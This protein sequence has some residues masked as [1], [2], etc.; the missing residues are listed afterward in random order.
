MTSVLPA[1][2]TKERIELTEKN[3]AKC[4][5]GNVLW[6]ARIKGLHLRVFPENK[7]YY[8]YFRTKAGV[9]RKPSLGRHGSITL[10]QARTA[11]GELLEQVAAGRDPIAEREAE[12]NAPLMSELWKR[13]REDRGLA[14][15]TEKEDERKWNKYLAK[16]H[17]WKIKDVTYEEVAKVF[18]VIEQENGPI[19]ANRVMA[20]LSTI[21]NFAIAPLRWV[22]INPVE[23]LQTNP[24]RKRKRYMKGHEAVEIG[25]LLFQEAQKNPASVAFLWLLILTGARKGE[26]AKARWHQLTTWKDPETGKTRGKLVLGEHKT[27]QDGEDRVI[28]LGPEAMD[29]VSK[30]P[31]SFGTITGIQDPKKLWQKIRET[32]KCPDLH[33]H[34]LR[35]SFAS[36][37]LALG[38][39]LAQSGE[40]LG[41]A[42]AETTKRYAHLVDEA[43]SN[44]SAK[45]GGSIME[46]MR[47]A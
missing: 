6:D 29:V 40:L 18:H 14:K 15:K 1:A 11:A 17:D 34:D 38:Y 7:V 42:S 3:I 28:Q 2:E 32:A 12:K 5:P 26:V 4:Q 37:A 27:D 13:Y 9:Q 45:I 36:E 24:E 41:H 31:R 30:L 21:M 39:N 22:E 25:K 8:L 46:K 16:F 47:G 33:M 23:G 35:H 44:A 10:A 43:A 19:M 20:L